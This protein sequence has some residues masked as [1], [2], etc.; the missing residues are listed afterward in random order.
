MAELKLLL[1]SLTLPLLLLLV[2]FFS[3]GKR[4]FATL[5]FIVGFLWLYLPSTYLVAY[6]LLN[7]CQQGTSPL[8]ISE[9]SENTSPEAIVILSGGYNRN[10]IEYPANRTIGESTLVRLRYGAT[11]AKSLELPVLTV[12]GIF[13]RLQGVSLAEQMAEVLSQEFNVPAKWRESG[14]STTAE[15]AKL[16]AKILA[17]ENIDSIILVTSAI[18]MRRAVMAFD[19]Y[20]IIVTPAPTDFQYDHTKNIVFRLIPRAHAFDL[21]KQAIHEI[22]GYWVYNRYILPKNK[23]SP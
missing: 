18:H 7:Y 6:A 17:A 23:I 10:I 1:F 12:G 5:C 15:N 8:D 19:R 3:R 2:A 14:S 21:S 13:D 22:L 20:G 4:V 9:L 16:S 11:V